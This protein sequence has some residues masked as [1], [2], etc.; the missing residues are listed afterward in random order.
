[1]N[2]DVRLVPKC[3]DQVKNK[4]WDEKGMQINISI[5]A[6]SVF[7]KF[8]INSIAGEQTCVLTSKI[9]LLTLPISLLS[10]SILLGRV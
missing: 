7:S 6:E 3:F 9:S 10:G 4:A 1:M 5:D 2:H 8:M